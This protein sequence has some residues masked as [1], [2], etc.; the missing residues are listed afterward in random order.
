MTQRK[1]ARVLLGL[2]AAATLSLMSTGQASATLTRPVK[3]S[4]GKEGTAASNFNFAGGLGLYL[5]TKKLYV[6]DSGPNGIYGFD[7]STPG[8][9]TPLAGFTPASTP[10]G[11][12]GLPGFGVDNS[13]VAPHDGDIFMSS[14]NNNHLYG[15]D[16]AG[17]AL[18]GFGGASGVDPAVY[19]GAPYGS[20]KDICGGAVDPSGDVWIANYSSKYLIEYDPTGT[21]VKAIDTSALTEG[22]RPCQMAFD[23]GNGDMYVQIYANTVWKLSAPGYSTAS[24]VKI[25]PSAGGPSFPNA[26]AVD[27]STHHVFVA[28]YSDIVE[29]ESNGTKTS[30]FG[31]GLET[32][33]NG[34]VLNPATNE[35]YAA[36]GSKVRVFGPPAIVPDITAG[37]APTS[38]RTTAD[39]QASVDPA[40]GGEITQ[41]KVEYEEEAPFGGFNGYNHSTSCSDSLPIS[42]P[43]EV[44]AHLSGLISQKGYQYR[45]VV[46]NANGSNIGPRAEFRTAN[47]ITNIQTLEATNVGLE[48]ATLNGSFEREGYPT[49]YYFQYTYKESFNQPEWNNFEIVPAPPP[50]AT[51]NSDSLSVTIPN[52]LEHGK[53]YF[54]RLIGI[55]EFGKTI[56][57]PKTFYTSSEPTLYDN[58]EF[59]SNVST[60]QATIHLTGNPNG[61]LTTY[62]IEYGTEGDCASNPCASTPETE[63]VLGAG[64]KDKESEFQLTGLE[65][66]VVYHYRV[67]LTNV[68]GVVTNVS[69]HK[70]KTFAHNVVPTGCPNSLA[71]QQTGA[72][73]LLDCRAFELVSAP[74]TGGYDVEST[75]N[76]GEKPYGGYPYAS[77]PSQVLYGIHNGAIPGIAG[78]PTNKGIDPYVAT[79]GTEGWTTRYVGIP[80][81]GTP[82]AAPFSSSL[83][84]ADPSL[85]TFAFGGADICAPCFGNGATGIPVRLSDGSL[86]QGMAG[87]SDPG[88][89]AAPDGLVSKPFSGDGSHF[90]FGSQ[91]PYQPDGNNTGDVSIYDRNLSTGV[92]QVVSKS[93]AGS[94]LSCLQGAGA[95]HSPGDTDGIAELDISNDGSRI[96]V[97][98]LVSTDPAGNDYFHLYMHIGSDSH[99]VDLTPGTT[100]GAQ[101]AGMTSDGSQVYFTTRDPLATS[102]SPDTDSSADLFRASVGPN[103]S[104]GLSRVSTGTGV[105]NGSGN[106]DGCDPSGDS[107]SPDNWNT[108]PGG[109]TDCSVVAIGGG[110]GVAPGDGT[111]YFLS[112]ERLDGNGQDGSPNLFVERPGSTPEFVTT[113][114][115]NANI[116]FPPKRH[117]LDY[118]LNGF[119]VPS[120]AAYDHSDESFYVLDNSW[121]YPNFQENEPPSFVQKFN[122]SGEL[123]QS[124]GASGKVDGSDSPT[125]YFRELGKIEGNAQW[126]APDSIAVDNTCADQG[127]SGAACTS[128]DPSN[129]DLYVPDRGHNVVDKFDSEGNYISQIDVT[130]VVGTINV[131]VNGVEVDPASGKVLVEVNSFTNGGV[132]IYDNHVNNAYTGTTFAEFFIGNASDMAIDSEGNAYLTTASFGPSAFVAKFEAPSYSPSLMPN[133]KG[134]SGIAYDPVSNDLFYDKGNS[135]EE[136]TTS[137]TQVGPSFGAE[138]LSNSYSLD[139]FNERL[140]VSNKGPSHSEGKFSIFTEPRI[141]PDL[142]YDSNLVI[143]SVSDSNTHHTEDFQVTPNGDYSTFASG[144][145]VTEYD[146]NGHAEVYR[147]KG[148]GHVIDCV[149]CPSTNAAATG[150]SRLASQGMNITED[151]RVFF[152]ASEPLVLRDTNGK[153]DVY[154]W[155]DGEVQPIS[156]G[157]DQ[158]GSRLLTISADGKDAYFFTHASLAPQDRNGNQVKIYDAREN[159]G[160][161]VVPSQPPCAASDECHGPGSQAAAPPDIGSF[162]GTPT[163]AA[164]Q[165]GCPKG[166][167]RRHGRCVSRH[168][169]GKSTKRHRKHHATGKRG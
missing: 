61:E 8:T 103:G 7:I 92:T 98:Q 13:G 54:F 79:R 68:K 155:K 145:P 161:F 164:S 90:V 150:D 29:Y 5:A 71:R 128:F 122:A 158:F 134:V 153:D 113:L 49:T 99:T 6:G 1:I 37:A 132:L 42:G 86:V 28:H 55:N 143:D 166:K 38:Q 148:E 81:D 69:D 75:L 93:P 18:A 2:A 138:T 167:V 72:A 12:S 43:Q 39:V 59:V 119:A 111:V 76:P 52:G 73:L 108:I 19:P 121:R 107:S 53:T 152:T 70:F 129:G 85:H 162:G 78:D 154:E 100:S 46:G 105:G 124:F 142:R 117:L 163:V 24:A 74:D 151:G 45:F 88:A 57:E 27:P 51:A 89:S 10:V 106:Y 135:V 21:F 123:D 63:V 80:A 141:P 118:E 4:F 47:A 31:A 17:N 9:F 169:K 11:P 97:G 131:Q 84:A 114:A 165:A 168:R 140:V 23:Q 115:S 133:S 41:C 136:V 160:F 95:C 130:P 104:M 83:L 30:E 137:G 25:D 64:V 44:T 91:L 112:P 65:P 146:S 101:F 3:Y 14:E 159:G 26:I 77:D 32:N 116:V 110:G 126:A 16:T 40:G 62:H 82:S 149:S 102:G 66:G 15:F 127:L 60:D 94:N 36:A 56:A 156:P 144:V 96:V 50:G 35:V 67:V 34:M 147:F 58:K 87:Q 125:G 109:P 48:S 33:F 157:A 139:A 20:P 120:G 22:G